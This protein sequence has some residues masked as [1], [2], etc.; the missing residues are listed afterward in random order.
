MSVTHDKPTKPLTERKRFHLSLAW[1]EALAGYSMI[2]PWVIGFIVFSL[3][4]ILATAYFSF[5]K[6][7]V[8]Q[9]PEFIGT[10]NYVRALTKDPLFW[11]SLSNTVFYVAFSVPSVMLLAFFL[12][13][14]LDSDRKGRIFNLYRTVFYL[15]YIIPTVAA[16]IVWLWLL[17]NQGGIINYALGFLNIPPVPWLV[18]DDWSKPSLI[19]VN[20]WFRTGATMVIYLAALQGIPKELY[21]AAEVDGATGWYKLLNITVPL[22][23]PSILFTLI[24]G[25]IDSFQVFNAAFV[26]TA[27]GP[28]NSTMF[29]L[30]YIYNNAFRYFDMGYASALAWILLLIVLVFTVLLFRGSRRWVYYEGEKT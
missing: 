23:T 21:E 1:R 20:L 5:T 29:Y 13:V 10:E 19:L 9:P 17:D 11:Q 4:P 16:S 22:M 26:M 28:L 6:Y 25:V 27:G 14:L 18:S 7:N 24:L 30:L 15:P 8:L 3:G 2:L 12:A